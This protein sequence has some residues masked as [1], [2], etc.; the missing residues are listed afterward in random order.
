M[1]SS[2]SINSNGGKNSTLILLVASNVGN[3]GVSTA[4]VELISGIG[5]NV[6]VGSGTKSKE[7]REQTKQ[8]LKIIR[9]LRT[10]QDIAGLAAETSQSVIITGTGVTSGILS[11]SAVGTLGTNRSRV[12]VRKRTARLKNGRVEKLLSVVGVVTTVGNKLVSNTH[13]TS[14]LTENHDLVGITTKVGNVV[15]NPL[16]TLALVVQTSVGVALSGDGI[17]TQ[18]SIGAGT[19]VD[20]NK[21][22]RLAHFH[23]LLDVAVTRVRSRRTKHKG[24][25]VNPNHDGELSIRLGASGAENVKVET[26]LIHG[27]TTLGHVIKRASKVIRKNLSQAHY[28]VKQRKGIARIKLHTSRAEVV[29][30]K[31]LVGSSERLGVLEPQVTNRRVSKWDSLEGINLA[32]KDTRDDLVAIKNGRGGLGQGA[33]YV[34]R[35]S[36][37]KAFG[38]HD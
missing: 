30:L 8:V 34:E 3:L 15:A 32:L 14:G 17:T 1:G 26:V 7:L 6:A 35:R 27:D 31:T 16:E 29:G 10:V 20:G 2:G 25:T 33:H 28:F 23:T 22:N 24:T 37:K 18:E 38:N 21:H 9:V 5:N 4:A 13:G 36:Q 12:K 19:V 11:K